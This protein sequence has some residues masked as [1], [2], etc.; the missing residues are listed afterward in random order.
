MNNI[1]LS[2]NSSDNEIERYF[3]AVFALSKSNNEFPVNLEE[4]WPLVYGKKSDAVEALR[5]NFIQGV[6]YQVLRQNPQ[7]PQGG[8][9]AE[10]YLL[11][12]PCMEFL[13]ARKVREVFEIYRKVYHMATNGEL[14]KPVHRNPTLPTKVKA[15]LLWADGI[16]KMLRLSDS[17]K[18]LLLKQIAEPLGMPTPDYVPSKGILKSAG[19]LL[20][21]NGTGISSMAFNKK[22]IE[23]GMM[24][25]ISRPS[26]HGKIK[27]FKSIKGKGLEYGENGIHPSNPKETQPQYYADRFPEL[28]QLLGITKECTANE[29]K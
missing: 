28:L 3:K 21:E 17:S 16:A 20:D 14:R 27:Y 18:L 26:S 12:V 11:T 15:S 22:M 24:E 10:D 9:P 6:D 25:E 29:S 8:R 7:N 19:V 13:V 5:N 4:V 1:V 23:A 2:K